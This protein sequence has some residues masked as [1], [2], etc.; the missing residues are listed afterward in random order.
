MKNNFLLLITVFVLSLFQQLNAQKKSSFDAT[1][2][3][4]GENV[5]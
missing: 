4:D 2:A 1:N 5:E 3:R